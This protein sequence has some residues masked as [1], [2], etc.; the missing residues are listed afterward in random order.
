MYSAT[1][2]VKYHNEGTVNT[3]CVRPV[4]REWDCAEGS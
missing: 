3:A 4:T 1:I 2:S